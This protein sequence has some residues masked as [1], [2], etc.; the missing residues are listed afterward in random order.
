LLTGA[1]LAAA[2]TMF[3]HLDVSGIGAVSRS[4]VQS[5]Q[6]SMSRAAVHI[7]D[8]SFMYMDEDLDCLVTWA[9]FLKDMAIY[10]LGQRPNSEV[11]GSQGS[12]HGDGNLTSSSCGS[13]DVIDDRR[14]SV[15]QPNVPIRQQSAST[16]KNGCSVETV[17]RQLYLPSGRS[18]MMEEI[19]SE[20][21]RCHCLL[22]KGE[23][24]GA[25][26]S[27]GEAECSGVPQ[28]PSGL[29]TG[30]G[31]FPK[32]AR[33]GQSGSQTTIGCWADTGAEASLD[34]ARSS[35]YKDSRRDPI[36]WEDVETGPFKRGGAAPNTSRRSEVI[37]RR[38]GIS[39]GEK[40]AKSRSVYSPGL[41]STSKVTIGL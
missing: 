10:F 6:L 36:P 1:E 32:L 20:I 8:E 14:K 12:I 40:Q 22:E 9:D 27:N 17:E 4:A 18:A 16:P 30:S 31:E 39:S 11:T 34:R 26:H 29:L 15:S 37:I 35:P 13:L 23:G 7:P 38:S 19:N 33:T 25:M 3:Q 28:L 24:H 41:V 2:K 5:L 21:D